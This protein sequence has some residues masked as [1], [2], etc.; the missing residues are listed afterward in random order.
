MIIFWQDDVGGSVGDD[1]DGQHG[2][3]EA[4]GLLQ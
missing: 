3:R 4:I 2:S 1:Y